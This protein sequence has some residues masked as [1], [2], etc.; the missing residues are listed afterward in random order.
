MERHTIKEVHFST[1]TWAGDY[2]IDWAHSGTIFL[3]DGQIKKLGNYYLAFSFDSAINSS[4]GVYS[5]VYKRLGTKGLLLKNGEIL[6]EINRSY[7]HAEVYEYPVAFAKL[8]DGR[9]ILIHC[10]NEYNRLEFEEVETGLIL[11]NHIDRDPSDFF[12]S[13]LEVSPDN[14]TLLSKGWA[15]HPFDYVE[16]FDIEECIENPKAL[17]Q[18]KLNPEVNTEISTAS[19]INNELVLI[20][21]SN[22]MEPFDDNSPDQLQNGQIG[23]WNL[24]TNTVSDIINPECVIGGNLMIIDDTFAWTFYEHPKIINFRT[25]EIVDEIKEIWSGKQVSSIIHTTKDLPL[26]SLNPKTRQIAIGR[27][28]TIEFLAKSI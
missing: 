2:L 17:D 12:H 13:R 20:G 28:D 3:P 11:T 10:P 6:R 5:V 9:D 22:D 18:S 21:A 1:L 4:D 7:Y 25:G 15:W 23:I 27:D 14:K 8:N 26:I 24:T 19:F 16:V